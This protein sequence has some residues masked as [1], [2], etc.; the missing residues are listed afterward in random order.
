MTKELVKYRFHGI[1]PKRLIPGTI[2]ATT[3]ALLCHEFLIDVQ[4]IFLTLWP[5]HAM[6]LPAPNQSRGESH[7]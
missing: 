4:H 6:N 5:L 3:V 2:S 1:G 7:R